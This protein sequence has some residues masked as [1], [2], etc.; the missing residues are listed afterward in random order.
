MNYQNV[1]GR[2]M[3]E[4]KALVSILAECESDFKEQLDALDCYELEWFCETA[5]CFEVVEHVSS[6]TAKCVSCGNIQDKR[7]DE[8]NKCHHTHIDEEGLH[9]IEI[10]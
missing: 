4:Y 8:C 2:Q 9:S 3:K 5:E 10:K 7:W 6:T 1:V